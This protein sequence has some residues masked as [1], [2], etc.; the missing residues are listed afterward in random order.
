MDPLEEDE[1]GFGPDTLPA[2]IA[3]EDAWWQ[4]APSHAQHDERRRSAIAYPDYTPILPEE[5]GPTPPK[6]FEFEHGMA[7]EE[8][9]DEYGQEA[10]AITVDRAV[11]LPSPL[12]SPRLARKNS[13]VRRVPPPRASHEFP[14]LSASAS[15]PEDGSKYEYLAR[16]GEGGGYDFIAEDDRG[17]ESGLDIQLDRA[18]SRRRARR[19]SSPADDG[20]SRSV[21]MSPP[22]RHSPELVRAS[23]VPLT[24]SPEDRSMTERKPRKLRR[25]RRRTSS[26]SG[27]STPASVRPKTQPSVSADEGGASSSGTFSR[28][29]TG[30]LRRI[31][32]RSSARPLTGTRSR[33]TVAR[34]AGDRHSRALSEGEAEWD[35]RCEHSR[36]REGGE[37]Y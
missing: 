18:P 32:S 8:L 19:L 7:E 16:G 34:E 2:S 35:L 9:Q 27:A 10:H 33:L 25:V 11:H 15:A 13:K 12:A 21:V 3:I 4:S 37:G 14:V 1:G 31:G 5:A 26:K 24:S 17:F 36:S 29:L 30:S 6:V 20:R 23:S 22:P 28:F